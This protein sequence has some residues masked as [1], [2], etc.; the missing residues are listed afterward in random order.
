M[1]RNV[2]SVSI[3][4]RIQL[5]GTVSD[6]KNLQITLEIR[7]KDLSMKI[8][9]IFLK[10]CIIIVRKTVFLKISFRCT[11]RRFSTHCTMKRRMLYGCMGGVSMFVSVN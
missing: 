4:I 5:K 9:T 6:K 10:K 11:E 3:N 8:C 7:K 2:A 1:S